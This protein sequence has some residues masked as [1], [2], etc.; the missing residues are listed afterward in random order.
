[1]IPYPCCARAA[2]AV[3]IRNVG[4]C[5]ALLMR[6]LYTDDLTMSKAFPGSL[7][8]GFRAGRDRIDVMSEQPLDDH[9]VIHRGGEVVAVVV[10][11]DE[12]RRLKLAEKIADCEGLLDAEDQLALPVDLAREYP[13]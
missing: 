13:Q 9:D 8:P 1:M 6:S 12:Y 7:A 3:R 5:I 2:S 11:L 4:S 10:P